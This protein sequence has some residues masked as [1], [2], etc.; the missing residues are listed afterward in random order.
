MLCVYACAQ[1]RGTVCSIVTLSDMSGLSNASFIFAAYMQ[2]AAGEEL[3]AVSVQ[4][5]TH[6][7][8]FAQG[9]LLL[10][11]VYATDLEHK[12]F[13]NVDHLFYYFVVSESDAAVQPSVL[14]YIPH[15]RSW[16]SATHSSLPSVSAVVV[17]PSGGTQRASAIA[18]RG[19]RGWCILAK[20]LTLAVWRGG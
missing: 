4:E 18:E 19:A 10:V 3:W 8:V 15:F 6:T 12:H 17:I 20:G 2:Q 16:R 11:R 1:E 9:T 7:A 13:V 5:K 14:T